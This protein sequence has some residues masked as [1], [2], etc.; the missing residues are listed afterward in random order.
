ME[1]LSI[2][3]SQLSQLISKDDSAFYSS[4][5]YFPNSHMHRGEEQDSSGERLHQYN[6]TDFIGKSIRQSNEKIDE[7]MKLMVVHHQRMLQASK[8]IQLC[9]ETK[10]FNCSLEHIESE[11]LLLLSSKYI[12]RHSLY[13][14]P[15]RFMF[16]QF[17]K[18]ER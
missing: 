14:Q 10:K 2:E 15:I 17:A 3:S 5:R 11:R 18:R 7:L 16:S 4:S 12:Y 6:E 1:D 9:K 13:S 8:A